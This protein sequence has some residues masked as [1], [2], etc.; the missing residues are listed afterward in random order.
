LTHTSEDSNFLSYA[1]LNCD[2]FVT[3]AK[4]NPAKAEKILIE[5]SVKDRDRLYDKDPQKKLAAC[6]L[7]N[8][9]KP[10]KLLLDIN[11][12]EKIKWKKIKRFLPTPRRFA[13]DRAPTIEEMRK[14]FNICDL[15]GKAM[16]LLM[17][18][19]GIREGAIEGICVRHLTPIESDGKIVAAR[20]VVYPGEPEEYMSFVTPEA[21]HAIQD[22]LSYRKKA[23]E[24]IGPDSPLIRDKFEAETRRAQ[25]TK[26]DISVHQPQRCT[27]S[28]VR[29]YF[30]RLFVDYGFRTEKRKSKLR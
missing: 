13:M 23:G 5:Y 18:S 11:D 7:V 26:M 8:R 1:G 22:Y 9:L 16:L 2:Q 3:L 24:N 30:N 29:H 21:Y 15:R 25:L 19:S 17:V 20:L 6:T 10:I 14:I 28:L 4:R 12:V 27:P